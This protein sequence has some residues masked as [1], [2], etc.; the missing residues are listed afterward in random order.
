MHNKD[1]IMELQK[2][3]VNDLEEIEKLIIEEFKEKNANTTTYFAPIYDKVHNMRNKLITD[4][5]I[6]RSFSL[7]DAKYGMHN[8]IKRRRV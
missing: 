4:I 2:H 3:I 7:K 8:S 1:K 5:Y 6:E